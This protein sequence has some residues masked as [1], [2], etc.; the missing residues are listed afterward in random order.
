MIYWLTTNLWTTGQ[1]IVTRRLMPKPGAAAEDERAGHRRR[2]HRP[3]GEPAASGSSKPATAPVALGPAAEGEA[4]ARRKAAALTDTPTVRVEATGETV[5]EAKWAALRELEQLVPGP[6]PRERSLPGG[7]RRRARACSASASRRRRSSRRCRHSPPSA[8]SA[9][10]D[11]ARGLRPADRR[12]HR[13]RRLGRG[14]RARGHGDG[15]L[16]RRRPRPAHREARPD[17]RRDPVPRQC[18]R[19]RRGRRARRRRRRGRLSRAAH[20]VSRRAREAVGPSCE[21]HRGRASRS[22]R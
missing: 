1:G 6:R 20:G 4:Q 13:R 17:A 5:G 2:T 16:L 11:E 21:Q 14:G 10:S 22:S 7:L 15:D 8:P 19:P 3:N 9:S 12:H 18:R